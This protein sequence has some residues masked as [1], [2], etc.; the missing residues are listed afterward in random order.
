MTT[1]KIRLNLTHW[2]GFAAGIG[3][4]LVVLALLAGCSN[5]P[6][7]GR[8][9]LAPTKEHIQVVLRRLDTYIYFSS[10]QIYHS[11]GRGQ[12]TFWDGQAWVRS[13]EP[14]RSVSVEEL[15]AS[16]SVALNYD[17]APERHHAEV[18]RSY[19]RNWHRSEAVLAWAH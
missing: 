15:E 6:A 1:N 7:W 13:N 10:Y 9:S 8:W 11:P 5:A 16:P 19:S 17:D 12:Y 3:L 4:G 18:V 2:A 14:P